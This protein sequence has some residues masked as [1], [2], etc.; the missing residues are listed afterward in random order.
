MQARVS[1]FAQNATTETGF[2]AILKS[3]SYASIL[4][5]SRRHTGNSMRLSH[6]ECDERYAARTDEFKSGMIS[7]ATYRASLFGLNYRG[8]DIDM[9]VR[10]N[11]PAD[12][13]IPGW[14]NVVARAIA[15]RIMHDRGD[16]S[17]MSLIDWE[18]FVTAIWKD[19]RCAR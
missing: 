2:T 11:K 14:V 13:S 18:R 3:N 19:N 10:Q 16:G 8:D 17:T 7:E 6:Q 4:L 1:S 5:A 12:D 9:A 15:V